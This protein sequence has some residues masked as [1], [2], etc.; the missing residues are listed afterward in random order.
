LRSSL[1]GWIGAPA[2]SAACAH[3][4]VSGGSIPIAVFSVLCF[5]EH[6]E[7]NFALLPFI[8]RGFSHAHFDV[9]LAIPT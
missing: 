7:I 3:A 9:A 4:A 6:F 2:A 5:N 1:N 8:D